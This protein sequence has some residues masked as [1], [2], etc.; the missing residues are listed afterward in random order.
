MIVRYTI[1][2]FRDLHIQSA[3]NQKLKTKPICVNQ[4]TLERSLLQCMYAELH[5]QSSS[6]QNFIIWQS[7]KPSG[8]F[9]FICM[10]ELS[11]LPRYKV[12]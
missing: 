11:D 12:E 9:I 8:L 3:R 5:F 1:F 10:M 4:D 2:L 7:T 6:S